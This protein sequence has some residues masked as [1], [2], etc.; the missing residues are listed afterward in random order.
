MSWRELLREYD[1]GLQRV[2]RYATANPEADVPL[3]V[4]EA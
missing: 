2:D 1:E 4:R 3:T